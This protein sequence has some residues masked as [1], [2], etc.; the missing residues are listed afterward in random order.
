MGLLL[1]FVVLMS[2]LDQTL[3]S[4]MP[5]ILLCDNGS[6]IPAA[7]ML[8]RTVAEKLSQLSSYSI[9]PVSLQ[10]ASSIPELELE[11]RRADVLPA[12]LEACLEQGERDFLVLPLFFG[13]SRAL[14]S[15]IPEQQTL[16]QEQYGPFGLNVAEVLYPLP[17]GDAM[18]VKLLLDNIQSTMESPDQ[19]QTVVLVDH[20]SPVS[21]VTAVRQHI[22]EQLTEHLQGQVTVEQ[23]VMERR[24]GKDY[25][26]NGPLLSD[27]L[28]QQ[29]GQGVKSVLVSLL[30]LLPGRHAGS[31]GDIETICA[32]AMARH[33]G[34]TIQVTPLIAQNDLLVE[35]LNK[36][37]QTALQSS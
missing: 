29:A 25:D 35:L 31:G 23:A 32:D 37:L 7:T 18:L 22:A 21:K 17:D 24:S 34:L 13:R 2:N 15:F 6:K 12:F 11:G 4:F 9:D 30:F 3:I 36:R 16:L 27:W 33:P 28:D 10:H 14:T 5:R 19:V 1:S 20:G 26:F 8:L